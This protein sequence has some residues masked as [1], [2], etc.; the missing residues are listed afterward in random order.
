MPERDE[1]FGETVPEARGREAEV[2]AARRASL[3]RL[4]R[5]QA[6]AL[7]LRSVLGVD[8]PTP[9]GRIRSEHPDLAPDTTTAERVVVAGRVVLL[10]DM[11]KIRFAT[12]RD[13]DGDLQLVFAEGGID[14]DRFAL[15]DEVD[16]GDIIGAEGTI[17]TTRR[18]ELSVFV[19]RWSMLTK[20]LRPLPEKWHGL[21]DP[22]LQQRRR[23]LHLIAD[24]TP[25]RYVHARAAT[26]RTVRRVLDERGFV[27]FEGPILQPVAG[28]ANARPFTTHHRALDVEM[29]LRISLELYLKRMLVGGLERVYELGRNFRNEGIDRDHNPEFTM[30]EAYQAYGDYHT[31]MDL[32]ESLVVACC[33]AVNPVMGRD[34]DEVVVPS[35]GRDLDL[36]P[37]FE[38]VTILGAVSEATGEAVTLDRPDLPEIAAKRDV[39][40]DDAWGPGK[41]V[42]ELFEKLVEPSIWRPTFV[43][44]FPREVS[45]L[46]R[47]NRDDPRLTEHFDLVAGGVELVTA[48]SELTDPIE[49]RAKFELQQQMKEVLGDEVH[50][51]DEEFLRALEHGMPPAGGMGMGIDRLLLLLTDAPSLRDLIMFPSHRPVGEPEGS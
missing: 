44:D 46:A 33:R 8:E 40:I 32:S 19:E 43:C 36:S 16:L 1:A 38:R 13:R 6:F 14:P 21:Q 27:E 11:G 39:A 22:D 37:P 24:D 48:F 49:Q 9:S 45:P 15:L 26:L 31:M 10:R 50:P 7:G 4:G 29:K 47:P 25:R 35:R 30:L 41:V 5:D 17:G 3:E 23:Y 2:L 34:P 42:Q 12:I 18:G 51:M 20:A 28:G